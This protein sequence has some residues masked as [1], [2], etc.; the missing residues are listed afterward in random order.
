LRLIGAAED[1]VEAPKRAGDERPGEVVAGKKS[2]LGDFG[3]GFWDRILPPTLDDK[4]R[5]VI[6]REGLEVGVNAKQA[7]R[8]SR[9]NAGLF[10]KLSRQGLFYRLVS[11]DTAARKVPAGAIAMPDQEHTRGSVDNNALYSKR[12][13]VGISL[14]KSRQ[15]RPHV[16]SNRQP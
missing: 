6:A 14:A 13:D 7:R 15:A 10:L 8:F 3:V 9:H 5:H 2:L 4:K 12:Y 1:F 16:H 11:F